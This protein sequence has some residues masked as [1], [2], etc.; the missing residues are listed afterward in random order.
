MSAVRRSGVIAD[1]GSLEAYRAYVI[2]GREASSLAISM[3]RE[4][5]TPDQDLITLLE[6]NVLDWECDLA[7]VDAELS[8]EA[9]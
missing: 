4:N 1:H 8:K 3:T 5:E 6:Q 9:A 7:W 2:K